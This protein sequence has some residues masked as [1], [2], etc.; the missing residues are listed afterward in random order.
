MA[1]SYNHIIDNS[2][3]ILDNEKFVDMIENLGDAYEACEELYGMIWWMAHMVQDA[4]AMTPGEIV[5]HARENYKQGLLLAEANVNKPG[6]S[7]RS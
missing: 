7:R 5:E 3:D 6:K 1:G 2:G 4:R